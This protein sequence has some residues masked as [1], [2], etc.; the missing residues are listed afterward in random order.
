MW[1]AISAYCISQVNAMDWTNSWA[2]SGWTTYKSE[3][4]GQ[5]NAPEVA[6]EIGNTNISYYD[7]LLKM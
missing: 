4:Q 6:K 2:P 5:L 3:H 7:I 1:F